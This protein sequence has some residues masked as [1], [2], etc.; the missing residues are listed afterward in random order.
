MATNKEPTILKNILEEKDF[1]YLKETISQYINKNNIGFDEF[2][3]KGIGHQQLPILQEY[4]KK[5]LPIAKNFFDSNNLIPTYTLFTEYSDT[6]ISLHKHKD[7]NACTYT[8]DLVLYQE[9]PWALWIEN[10]KYL[11]NENEAIL[12][13]GEEQLHWREPIENNLDKIGVIF[14]HYVEPDH[15]WFTKGPEHVKVIRQNMQDLIKEYN[16]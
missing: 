5:L 4:S 2:G 10:K 15:W 14:F 8:I 6:N 9:K 16:S 12:F 13:W 11:A 3:R 1:I 7:A